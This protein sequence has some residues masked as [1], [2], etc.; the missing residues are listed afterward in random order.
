MAI[1]QKKTSQPTVGQRADKGMPLPGIKLDVHELNQLIH[2]AR[3]FMQITVI[4]M[5]I[6]IFA[7]IIALLEFLG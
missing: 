5:I 3:I 6:S 4:S 2:W 7:G 1:L